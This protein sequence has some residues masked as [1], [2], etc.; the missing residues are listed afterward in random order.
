MPVAAPVL[1]PATQPRQAL[2]QALGVPDLD[3]VAVQACLDPLPDQPA[4]HRVGVAADVDGAAAVHPHG[5]ALAGVEP[6]P[7]QRAQQGQLLGQPHLPAPV[8]LGEQLPQEGFVRRPA[9]E[10]PAAAQH[11]R[12]VQRPLELPVA[13]LHV[14]VLMR[15]RR[16]DR[17]APQAVV[18]Q[19]RLVAELKGPPIAAGGDGRRQGVGPMHLGGAAQLGQGILQAVAEALEALAEADRAGLPVGVGQHEVVDQVRKRLAADGHL[20]AA[21]VREVGGAQPARLVDLAEEHLLGGA[22]QGAPLLDV[23]LQGA[24]LP[25]GKAPRVL[26]LQPVEHSLGLQARVEGQ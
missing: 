7:G 2:D 22:V 15:P 5:D 24:Q 14:A 21:G 18:P 10:V 11:Q 17:L 4:G 20:Q 26:A 19:Q 8:A 6:L 25:L 1:A 9:G 13:L 23:P 16:V 12:L 3:V